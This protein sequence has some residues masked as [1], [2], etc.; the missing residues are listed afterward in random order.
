MGTLYLIA[1]PIGNLEDLTPRAAR[2][3]GSVAVIACEDTRRTAQLVAHCGWRTPLVSY[4]QHNERERTGALLAR[5]TA[6]QDVALVSDAGMPLLSDPGL[7]LVRE[8]VKAGITVTPVPGASAPIAALALSG[9]PAAPFYFA[10]FLPA[11][12]AAR[13]RE[14]AAWR[15]RGET[16]VCFEAPH[17]LR[18]ALADLEAGLGPRRGLA[19]AR[20]LTKMHEQAVRGEI[21]EVRR[22]FDNVEPR[23]EFT[24]VLAPAP[25]EEAPAPGPAA[26]MVAGLVA[27]GLDPKLAAKKA[28]RQMG[29]P[30]AE[31]YREWRHGPGAESQ[32]S[33]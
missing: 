17:R 23:G 9:F 16:I 21:A 28:A 14:I 30:R 1:T 29:R 32:G 4:H 11:R 19:V 20:E 18:A 13:Q 12:T 3:L 10:G 24:L 31:V 26:D 2:L 6:G 8:A 22:H 5:L 25:P 7:H 27:Q 15:G 33:R